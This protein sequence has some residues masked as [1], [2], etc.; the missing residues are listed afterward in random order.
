MSKRTWDTEVVKVIK[1]E[2]NQAL[3]ELWEGKPENTAVAD[4]FEVLHSSCW[5]C[6][7]GVLAL[8]NKCIWFSIICSF[9]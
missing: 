6:Q 5:E 3:G 4:S 7:C 8:F 1:R 9:K 2:R